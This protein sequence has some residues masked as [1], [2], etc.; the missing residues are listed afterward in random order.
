MFR[1]GE[2]QGVDILK[3]G[4]RTKAD[5]DG[6]RG[7]FSIQTHSGKDMGGFPT[8][9][10]GAG[11]DIDIRIAQLADDI[12]AGIT[13]KGNG[14]DMGRAAGSD[15]AQARD[16]LK[17]LESVVPAV[18][19]M[20]KNGIKPVK[21]ELSG[22]SEA[23]D[24]GDGLSPRPQTELLPAAEEDGAEVFRLTAKIEGA[25]TLRTADLMRGDRNEVGGE[26]FHGKRDFQKSLDGVSV[27]KRGM[28]FK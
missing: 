8:M 20:L 23:N 27:E 16:S 26:V 11:R 9:A 25:D 4:V 1:E 19:K 2:G 24:L 22:L 6:S 15:H 17:P 18:E 21:A 13:R 10:S 14:E 7:S 3:G 28:I 12:L 5:A